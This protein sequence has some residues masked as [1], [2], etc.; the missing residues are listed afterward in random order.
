MRPGPRDQLITERIAAALEQID[1]SL[2]ERAALD[3]AEGVRRLSLHLVA[4]LEPTL[5]AL[6]DR[7]QAATEQA[8]MVNAI[9]QGVDQ[10]ADRVRLPPE[11]LGGI[12]EPPD[13]LT[14]KSPALILP[15]TS[16]STSD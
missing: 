2:I 9:L 11:V 14:G 5:R 16:L 8:T 10:D 12:R 13:P 7:P 6:I 4:E 15:A 1:E 3:G